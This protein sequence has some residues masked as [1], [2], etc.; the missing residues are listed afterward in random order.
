MTYDQVA[1]KEEENNK[2]SR[3]HVDHLFLSSTQVLEDARKI[4]A[5]IFL[6]ESC[7]GFQSFIDKY[8]GGRIEKKEKKQTT[9][10]AVAANKL[11]WK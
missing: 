6:D 1:H 2:T 10:L 5:I 3:N 9:I 7:I 8:W 4:S 11:P